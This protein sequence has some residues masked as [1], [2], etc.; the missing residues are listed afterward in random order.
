MKLAV[1][2][3]ASGPDAIPA[4]LRADRSLMKGNFM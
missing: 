4:V 3:R 2:I 1:F